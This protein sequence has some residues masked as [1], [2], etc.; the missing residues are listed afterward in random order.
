MCLGDKRLSFQH[1]RMLRHLKTYY[2]I[3]QNLQNWRNALN[4]HLSVFSY[5]PGQSGQTD[6]NRVQRVM[7][8]GVGIRPRDNVH[9]MYRYMVR[10]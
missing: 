7:W 10:I 8:P 6:K 4:F 9:T 2:I 1:S 5:K 3:R